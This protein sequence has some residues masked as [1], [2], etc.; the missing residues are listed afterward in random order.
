[1]ARHRNWDA[2]VYAEVVVRL[3]EFDQ[4]AHKVAV[5]TG[6]NYVQ[7]RHF[8]AQLTPGALPPNLAYPTPEQM[9]EVRA[10][11]AADVEAELLQ[12]PKPVVTSG[13]EFDAEVAGCIDLVKKC[14]AEFGI[15]ARRFLHICLTDARSA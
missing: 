7:V 11:V 8:E 1:M 5:K 10:K 13:D 6:L 14:A 12:A 2:R 9:D 4:N 15:S 3:V